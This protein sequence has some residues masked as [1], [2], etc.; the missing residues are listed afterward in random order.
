LSSE[1]AEV[2]FHCQDLACRVCFSRHWWSLTFKEILFFNY[3][4]YKPDSK[5]MFVPVFN[6]SSVT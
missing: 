4:I 5:D 3:V 1:E 2:L 6:G